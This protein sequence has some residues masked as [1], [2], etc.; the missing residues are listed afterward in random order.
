M[1]FDNTDPADLQSL[2]TEVNTDP[3]SIGYTPTPT[4]DLLDQLNTFEANDA[5]TGSTDSTRSLDDVAVSEVAEVIDEA[6]YAALDEYDKDWVKTLIA[7]PEET[8]LRPY[9]GKFL[10]VF[11]NGTTTRTNATALLTVSNSSRAEV[12]YGWGTVITSA[13]WSAARDYTP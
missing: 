9:K 11:P 8:T 5:G 2:Q 3:T 7:Q 4:D 6:E 13:D 1:A 10:E 12:L